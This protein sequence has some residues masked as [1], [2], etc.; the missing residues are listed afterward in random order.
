MVDEAHD[1]DNVLDQV[2]AANYVEVMFAK[3]LAE[4]NLCCE[5]LEKQQIPAR[6]ES[7]GVVS[8]ASG[9]AVLVPSDRFLEASELLAARLQGDIDEESAGDDELD[10]LDDDAEDE[11]DDDDD[12][13]DDDDLDDDDDADV[14]EEEEESE[15]DDEF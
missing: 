11:L 15:K 14:L 1:S 3:G 5:Y 4:A 2:D 10:E 6:I 9:V 12:D 7:A 13:D 8:R